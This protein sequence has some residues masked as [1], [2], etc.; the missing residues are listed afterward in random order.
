MLY[1]V[2]TVAER[3]L[4]LRMIVLGY[5]PYVSKEDCQRLGVEPVSLA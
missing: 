4:G 5:D 3:G 1:E 2:I